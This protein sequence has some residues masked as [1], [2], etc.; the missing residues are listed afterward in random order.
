MSK[1]HWRLRQGMEVPGGKLARKGDQLLTWWYGAS[2]TPAL[3]QTLCSS[4]IIQRLVV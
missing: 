2:A 4:L 1:G 3:V